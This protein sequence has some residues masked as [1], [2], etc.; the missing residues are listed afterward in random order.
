MSEEIIELSY[1]RPYTK[2]YVGM[3]ISYKKTKFA[4]I[5]EITYNKIYVLWK[6]SP[7]SYPMEQF[8]KYLKDGTFKKEN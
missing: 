3:K 6:D 8:E 5:T 4:N 1:N 2:P 7:Q